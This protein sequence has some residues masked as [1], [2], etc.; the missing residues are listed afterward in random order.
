M[1]CPPLSI[2][3][4]DCCGNHHAH[5]AQIPRHGLP[6]RTPPLRHLQADRIRPFGPAVG[7]ALVPLGW[8]RSFMVLI[9]PNTPTPSIVKSRISEVK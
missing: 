5:A 9:P 8:H 1:T 6:I 3:R 7:D 4:L 2:A